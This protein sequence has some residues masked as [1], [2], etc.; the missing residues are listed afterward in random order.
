MPTF[1]IDAEKAQA[2]IQAFLEQPMQYQAM[3]VSKL[4]VDQLKTNAQPDPDVWEE[5][6]DEAAV[7]VMTG[8]AEIRHDGIWR[9]MWPKDRLF[10]QCDHTGHKKEGHLNYVEG[11]I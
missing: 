3:E 7:A 8:Q 2:V 10:Y 9:K 5:C 4:I 6:K 11:K 1:P